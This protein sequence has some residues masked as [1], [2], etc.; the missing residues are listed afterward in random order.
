MN[1]RDWITIIVSEH[2]V[3]DNCATKDNKKKYLI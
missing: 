3:L 2:K 1:E